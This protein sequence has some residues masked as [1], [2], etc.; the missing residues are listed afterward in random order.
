MKEFLYL[1]CQW[2]WGLPQNLVG[3]AF[4]LWY[5]AKGCR[6]FRYQGAKVVVWPKK[7]GSM[8]MGSFL[9]M[10]PGWTPENRELLAHEYGHTIQ[11]LFFGPLYLLTVGVPSIIWAGSPALQRRRQT[12]HIG[13]YSVYPEKQASSLGLRFAKKPIRF[14][15]EQAEKAEREELYI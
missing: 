10:Y 9:F 11:S 1:L 15:P 3:A 13:Y 6:H 14:L 8:S 12:R 7:T 5:R 2:T 4:Y